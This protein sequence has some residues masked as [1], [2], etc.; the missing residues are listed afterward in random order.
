MSGLI[1]KQPNGLY[2]RFSTVVDTFTHINMTA[3]D[4][5]KVIQNQE[6]EI[7]PIEAALK[8]KDIIDNWLQPFDKVITHWGSLNDTWDSFSM[9]LSMMGYP[10]TTVYS[11]QNCMQCKM[12]KQWLENNRVPFIKV[13]MTELT[14]DKTRILQTLKERGC[15]SFPVIESVQD[16]MIFTGFDVNQ[17][18]TLKE[19]RGI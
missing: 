4:Y 9:K 13:D 6:E 17:L 18:K 1:T 5:A 16:D 15:Q 11:R 12:A 7:N 3:A 2:A 14:D 8:A 10:V 19:K